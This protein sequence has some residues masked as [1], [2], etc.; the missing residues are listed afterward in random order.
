M[1]TKKSKTVLNRLSNRVVITGAFILMQFIW[2]FLILVGVASMSDTVNLL[3]RILGIITIIYIIG[4]DSN[5]SV[6]IA[7]ILLISLAPAFGAPL[8]MLFGNK[9]PGRSLHKRL[10]KT[11][12]R[13][14]N[15]L[16]FDKTYIKE[17]ESNHP[18]IAGK[19]RYLENYCSYPIYKNTGIKYFPVGDSMFEDMLHDL[20]SAQDHI[21]ME[22]FIIDEGIMWQSILDIL[23]EKAQDGVD[24]RII[25]DD[26]GCVNT[27]PSNFP[28]RMQKLNIKVVAFNRFIPFIA[29]VM[30]HRDHRKI[31]VIDSKIAY[32]GGINIAD[33]Y[34]NEIE[35]F[36][37][38]KDNGMRLCGD[39]AFGFT[40]MFFEMWDTL[41]KTNDDIDRFRKVAQQ[42]EDSDSSD[43]YVQPFGDTPLD[44]EDV[45]E[46]LYIDIIGGSCRYLYIYT[47]YLIINSAMS[48]A[49][50]RAAKRGVDVRIITPA[51]PDKKL[52]H[53]MTRSNYLPLLQS[54]VK[55][56][57][58]TPG[59]LHAK[60]YVADDEIAIVGSINMDYRS[61]NLH[62]EC[63]VLVHNVQF[64]ADMKQDFIQTQS[65]SRKIEIDDCKTSVM[66]MLYDAVMRVI[67]PLL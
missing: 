46:S 27:L 33:E 60:S 48:N 8:Y 52:I 20:R 11:T 35:R 19:F 50:K 53:R 58:Y 65:Q 39:A 30:N 9:Y 62:F 14:N 16:K 44:F 7:W 24:V 10:V 66:G 31:L 29:A 12:E 26:V 2:L 17:I 47:P 57:E 42:C 40:L 22:Y 28:I 54:G 59:F 25:Y 1:K 36:G 21:F 3:I 4:T 45:A 34:I 32:T 43:C 49:L 13:L 6:K 23:I 67:S 63:G 56:Y 64:T 18:H 15:F 61:L 51:I 37:H 55:I 5:S 38:W 41:Q